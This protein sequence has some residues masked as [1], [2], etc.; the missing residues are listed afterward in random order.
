MN[1][2]RFQLAVVFITA[3]PI[4]T[5]AFLTVFGLFR[6]SDL[7][8]FGELPGF[9]LEDRHRQ[10]I[11]KEALIGKV[12][13]ANFLFTSCPT[14][15][16]IIVS[17][18]KRIQ[19]ALLLKE[20]FR[21]VS[22]SVD[23]LRDTPEVLSAYADRVGADPFKWMFLTGAKKDIQSLVQNGFRLSAADDGGAL[24]SDI[25]HSSKLVL[26]DH[27]GRIRGYYDANETSDVRQAIKDAKILLKKT[28]EIPSQKV[29]QV[30][31]I[32]TSR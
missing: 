7:K 12:W 22:I 24:G 13:I 9:T 19:K 3:F 25:I 27:T 32:G 4:I 15:C 23:P 29:A 6:V 26:V 10:K 11:S 17:E 1:K 8:N 5:I 30:P 16:P 14:Q 21:N 18:V 20:N 28:F 31:P 2:K